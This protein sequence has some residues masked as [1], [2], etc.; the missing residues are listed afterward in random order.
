M[1][2]KPDAAE[3]D[4]LKNKT[5]TQIPELPEFKAYVNARSGM[6]SAFIDYGSWF[7]L[8]AC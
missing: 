2:S 4:D 8:C 7:I 1:G 3:M 5:V 6:H